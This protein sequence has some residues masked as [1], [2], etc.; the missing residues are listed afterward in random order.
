MTVEFEHLILNNATEVEVMQRYS[1]LDTVSKLF[2]KLCADGLISP[3]G[4]AI[5]RSDRPAEPIAQP[6]KLSQR[7][8]DST[9]N[10]LIKE[11][12]DGKSSYELA[13]SYNL[14]KGSVIR[15]LREAGVAIRRQSLTTGQIEEA[16]QLYEAGRSLAKI[17]EHISANY[18]TV[19]RALKKR[20]VQMRDTHG[21]PR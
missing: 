17:G 6:F 12:E 15:L 21:R 18:G 9:V 20:G 11:Y 5:S 16:A 19:W 13:A 10:Q 7:L 2:Q 3:D 14:N 1:N 4:K 8:D